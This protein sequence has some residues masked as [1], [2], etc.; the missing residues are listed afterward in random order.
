[1]AHLYQRG[2]VGQFD[3]RDNRLFESPR[4]RPVGGGAFIL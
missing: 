3:L 1:M 2:L 4:G